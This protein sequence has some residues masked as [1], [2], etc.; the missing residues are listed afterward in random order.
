MTNLAFPIGSALSTVPKKLFPGSLEFSLQ[1]GFHTTFV[2]FPVT[3]GVSLKVSRF[4]HMKQKI[5][6]ILTSP[7]IQ[8]NAVILNNCID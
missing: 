1:V 6:E 7:K 5:H 2:A 3:K 4:Q 8:K